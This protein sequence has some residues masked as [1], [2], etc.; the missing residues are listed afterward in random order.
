MIFLLCLERA[1]GG[2]GLDLVRAD[3][4]A[5]RVERVADQD[6]A[7]DAPEE[8]RVH[9]ETD[10][11]ARRLLEAAGLLEQQ[12][13][14]AVEAGVTERLAVLGDVRA[15]AARAARAGRDE[16]V[17]LDDVFLRHAALAKTVEVLHE[18][19]DGEVRRVA[20]AAVAV[21]ASVLERVVIRRV[22]REDLVADAAQRRLDEQVVRHRQA[23][24]EDRRVLALIARELAR[25][26]VE[27]VL[28]VLDGQAEALALLDLELLELLPRSPRARVGR[29]C[30]RSC[31]S[32]C[33]W[34]LS[35]SVSP[36]R[37]EL[38]RGWRLRWIQRRCRP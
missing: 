27:P 15:E 35:W 2:A 3:A 9:L 28:G 12:H 1:V 4:V 11:L 37:C 38:W 8:R 29:G 25:H 24:D 5:E 23:R 26:R 30:F 13:A 20:L 16:H 7:D 33:S 14:E 22:H 31:R 19:A 36:A 10:A 18:V 6:R 21:L 34:F 32:S 17:V